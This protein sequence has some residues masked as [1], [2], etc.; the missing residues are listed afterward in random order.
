MRLRWVVLVSLLCSTWATASPAVHVPSRHA[1]QLFTA[2]IVSVP[3]L[4]RDAV[5]QM[6]STLKA[7]M[8]AAI[9]QGDLGGAIALWELEMGRRAPQWLTEFQAAFNLAN[10]RAG[11]CVEVAKSIFEGFKRLGAKPAYVRFTSAG[12]MRGANIIAWERRAGEPSSTI[13]ISSNFYHYVVQVG[14]RVYD[15]MTGPTGLAVTEYTKRLYSPG[16][17]SMQVVSELP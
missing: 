2:Q 13:Q 6:P 11:P 10:Q 5:L 17:L 12:S 7:R 4:V 14:D 8:L 9:A 16:Q 3:G 15:A 1:Q